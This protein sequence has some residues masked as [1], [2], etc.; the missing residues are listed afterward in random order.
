MSF[1]SFEIDETSPL[2]ATAVHNGHDLRGEVAELMLLGE[3]DRLR[4]ED[5]HTAAF[6]RVAPS[7]V[8]AHRSRF[9]VDLNRERPAAIYRDPDDAWG[10]Q[11]WKEALP[12][13]VADRSMELFDAFYARFAEALDRLDARHGGVLVFDIHSYNHRRGGPDGP[14]DDRAAN[15]EVNVGTG[16]LDRARWGSLV[17]RFMQDMAST[18]L[19]VRENVR[20]QGREVAR[21][22]HE[23][24]PATGCCLC[25]EFKKI[26]MN[27]WTG[28]VDTGR[29]AEL[30]DGLAATVPGALEEFD[31]VV[32]G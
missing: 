32:T 26:F 24:L 18:G 23:H 6:T 10:L 2:L 14:F 3:T 7:R 12:V 4:E 8:I 27:E 17:D 30:I 29:L 11:V 25:I 20:F 9:E 19:D 31:K 16:T 21:F 28:E 5:P 13:E 15:P 22:V 1:A